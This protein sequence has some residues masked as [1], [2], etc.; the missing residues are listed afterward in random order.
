MREPQRR[1]QLAYEHR[2]RTA[3]CG[4]VTVRFGALQ[5][6]F[7]KLDVPIA[8]L[9]PDEFV[10]RARREVEAIAVEILRDVAFRLLQTAEEPAVDERVALRRVFV[11]ADVPSF[12]VHQHEARRVP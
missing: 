10:E 9:V 2:S 11:E 8:I 7:G 5:L 4:F 1:F 3:R 12:D 6:H